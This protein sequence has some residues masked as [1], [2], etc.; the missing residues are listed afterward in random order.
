MRAEPGRP[1]MHAAIS[2]S[3][4]Q[5]TMINR[6]HA[7]LCA[8]VCASVCAC[9]YHFPARV[10][11]CI[12]R[13]EVRWW[14][15]ARPTVRIH[16]LP[17]LCSSRSILQAAATHSLPNTQK[18]NPQQSNK[19]GIR[20]RERERARKQIRAF[21]FLLLPSSSPASSSRPDSATASGEGCSI[22]CPPQTRPPAPP[23]RPGKRA[24]TRA[25]RRRR[26]SRA[27]FS[28]LCRPTAVRGDDLGRQ[29]QRHSS[30][31]PSRASNRGQRGER[32]R[33]RKMA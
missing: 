10:Y 18:P 5:D 12:R 2:G 33:G 9:E 7:F 11:A 15:A 6:V 23:A 14:P 19:R 21:S 25:R 26:R 20:E 4:T 16:W 13:K 8:S 29:R 3:S 24:A 31:R 28:S 1:T 32:E 22:A 27:T 17:L 30:S